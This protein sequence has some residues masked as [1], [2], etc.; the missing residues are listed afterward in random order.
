MF[1]SSRPNRIKMN[2]LASFHP[3]VRDWFRRR[4]ATMTL[5][6]ELGWPVI[7][8][9]AE[10]PGHDVLLCAPTGSG[11][12]LAAFLWTINQLIVEA[13]AGVLKDEVSV[14]YVSPLKALANDIR[15][16][17]EEPLAGVD[18]AAR[19]AG[20]E[21]EPI[22]AGLRTGDTPVAE[23]GAML[24]HP[25][26]ILVTTP[27]SLFIL[28]TSARFRTKL[29]AVRYVIV[30]EL[31]A[32][33]G[34]KRGAHLAL[35]LERLERMVRRNGMP[36]PVRIGLSATLNPITTL[37]EFLAGTEPSDDGTRLP[38][39]VQIV[40]ADTVRREVDIKVI[41][42]GPELGT[43][44]THPH[45]DAMYD[46]VAQLIREHQ[47]TL[48]FTLSRR[49]A[50][51][52]A[53]A[54]QKRLGE[55][56][57]AAHHGSLARAERL[58][59][60][61]R[62]KRGELK[63]IVATASLELGIDVGAVDLVCQ[64]DSPKG[65]A[66]AIQ[67]IGR[68]GH[69]PGAMP[70]GRF[71]ALNLDDLIECAAAVRAMRA[72]RMD[73]VEVPALGMDV[74]AQQ[75]VAIAAEEEEIA[76]SDLLGILRGAYNFAALGS[77]QLVRLLD[78]MATASPERIAGAAPKI[79]H[80]RVT[81]HVRAR[82][83]ARLAVLT[84]GG[85]I[86][87]SGNYD[88]VIEAQ[89]RKIGDVEEDFAQ[90]ASRHD[91]FALGSMPW[92]ILRISKN[93][94]MVEAAPGMAPT[95]PWW[96]TE[97]AGRSRALSAEV[98]AVRRGIAARL[99]QP[100]GGEAAAT[101]W[102]GEE[103]G[104]DREAAIQAVAHVRR[105]VAALGALPD[106]KTIVFERFFDGLGGTQIVIHAPFGMRF[107]R[108]LGLALR[109]R[110]CQSFDFEIQA[111]AIDDAVLL[112]LNSRHSFPLDYISAMLNSR[113]VRDCLVQAL[114]DAPMF[115][116]RLRHVATRALYI[117]RSMQGRKVPAWIQRLRT[118]ELITSLFPQ[119]NACF[120]NRPPAIEIPDHFVVAETVNECLSETTDVRQLEAVMRGLEDRSIKA[121]YVDSVAPSVFAQ[122]ILMTWDYSFLDDGERANRRSRTVTT[123]R[124]IAEDAFRNEDL[125][126]MLA[127]E[128]V[129]KVVAYLKGHGSAQPRTPDEWYELVRKH[130]AMSC[131]D[132]AG[133]HFG[134]ADENSAERRRV[135][136]ELERGKRFYRIQIR[137]GTSEAVITSEDAG[138]F[139]AAYPELSFTKSVTTV[140]PYPE[141]DRAGEEIVRRALATSGPVTAAQLADRLLLPL[142]EVAINLAALEAGGAIFRGYF[143]KPAPSLDGITD[144][145]TEQWC[146]RY[147]LERI[148]RETLGRLRAEVEPCRDE[149]FAAFRLR[150]FHLGDADLATGVEGTRI[151]MEQLAG[152]PFAP[153]IWEAAILPARIP[154]YRPEYLDL[155]CMGGDLR[156]IAIPPDDESVSAPPVPE[157]VAFVSRQMASPI[158]AGVGEE[159]AQERMADDSK[160]LVVIAALRAGG[161]QYLDQVAD[162]AEL[163]ERDTLIALWRL[164]ARGTVSN[165]SFAPLRLLASEP[166]AVDQL[167]D[168]P[169][170]GSRNSRG[171]GAIR[172]DAAVR[173][174]LRSNLSG[175]WSLL[176][177]LDD[178]VTSSSIRRG[179]AHAFDHARAIAQVL[180]AR[181][182]VLAREMLT[183]ESSTIAW[184][185]LVFA[186]RRMEYGG[187]IRRGYFV[188][189]LSGEQYALPEALAM[190]RATRG[191]SASGVVAMT[192]ADPAN[193]YGSLLPGCGIAR[194]PGNLLAISNGAVVLGVAGKSLEAMPS[195]SD[196][197]FTAAL[198]ALM[199]LRSKLTIETIGGVPALESKWVRAMTSMGFHSNGRALVYDGLHGPAP[200]LA[201]GIRSAASAQ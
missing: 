179:E 3:I 86:P 165:D 189:S 199:N 147:V 151:V 173:A 174:R 1:G 182:G 15:L 194:E 186:L 70:K 74:L 190:L 167:S 159:A 34:S 57:V 132:L 46:A 153:A 106:E 133:G 68:S 55:D 144:E 81:M 51:R 168:A 124:S 37:A 114:L 60:E 52:I 7:A 101:Q 138:L 197:G 157:R 41:A 109:K 171:R 141:P 8:Q 128:A 27:E 104:L 87:E 39:R 93:R 122:R 23:R 110:L 11:K 97:A 99:A 36:R 183:D 54:L 187:M 84:S 170:N 96:Q 61:Q 155:L 72:G 107:N 66:A 115:E 4:F 178:S 105:G 29:A 200:A 67:R 78:Q 108:G 91:V 59:A 198:T 116:V 47:T 162:R 181:H 53:L 201:R 77:D 80:D 142:T 134:G 89:S 193:P 172:H 40:R 26:H 121:V 13:Q 130:G 150:W 43:L 191:A 33:A 113:T 88:V 143:T 140:E 73:E 90:E 177:A 185:D 163:S 28:L 76:D 35:T 111:S 12:T 71:F 119:R 127:A 166:H 65:I 64:I 180:L 44:A 82:R 137:P 135:I 112:A 10:P 42:P 49:W 136:A 92:R 79:F 102:L 16:N 131:A 123:N 9:A 94:L 158:L 146:D 31:H 126:S 175:R 56:A 14:L 161:A 50:E 45:W 38:R 103:C 118:Q 148:H 85:T 184:K 24:R 83:G 125:S 75:I 98:S 195:L 139:A 19:G 63:A 58:D 22:R 17:L 188:R 169:R 62:L 95:L 32:V 5:A 18:E 145:S 48:V 196:E 164:A 149:E 100:G 192:A 154:G 160:S 30:D 156:W 2:P 120:E 21:L 69:R 25:P 129:N 152:L 117:M 176:D 6:Q 20:L